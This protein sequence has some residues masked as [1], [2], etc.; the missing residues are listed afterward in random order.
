VIR[1]RY[2]SQTIVRIGRGREKLGFVCIVSV[3]VRELLGAFQSPEF[4]SEGHAHSVI[5]FLA[6][7]YCADQPDSPGNYE[8][9]LL[10]HRQKAEIL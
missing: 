4:D 3:Q 1:A 7:S 8:L 5:R 10:S 9:V 6:R 2:V